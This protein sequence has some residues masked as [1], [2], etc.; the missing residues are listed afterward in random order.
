MKTSSPRWPWLALAAALLA[1]LLPACLVRGGAY[2]AGYDT[3]V[4]VG[5]DYYEPYGPFYGGW[6][7][8]Y[9]VGP[10][11]GGGPPHA[12]GDDHAAPR[13]RPAPPARPV[14]SIPARPR[15]RPPRQQG[16]PGH[17]SPQR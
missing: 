5:I 2:G 4:G 14:P 11:R 9:H 15:P 3:S 6:A 13:Y 7:P 8:G 10:S 12:R 17:P 1:P 16:L